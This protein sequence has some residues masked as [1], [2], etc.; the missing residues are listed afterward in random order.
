MSQAPQPG[1]IGFSHSDGLMGKA[2]RF[3][4]RIR[5]GEKPSHWNHAFIVD[6]VKLVGSVTEGYRLETT[7]I[8][9]EPS[10]VTNDKPISSVGAY[11]LMEPTPRMSRAAILEFARSQVGSEYGWGSIASCALDCMTPNWAPSFRRPGTWICS[12]LVAEALR[13]GGWLHNF[14]DIYTVTPA[15]LF[16]AF[17]NTN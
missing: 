13:F 5:W 4:E 17:G 9:A 10:G 12:A 3:G 15:Q 7:V 2:I 14:D 16:E 1:D 6:E 8:Q 11:T